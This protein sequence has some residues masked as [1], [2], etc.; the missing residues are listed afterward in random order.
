MNDETI[1]DKYWP[2][3]ISILKRKIN[4]GLVPTE[5]IEYLKNRYSDSSSIYESLYRIKNHIEEV[6]T[7]KYCGKKLNYMTYKDGGLYCGLSCSSRDSIDARKEA[8]F[9]KYGCYTTLKDPVVRS[10]IK[11]TF[12]HKSKKEKKEIY[13]K[14]KKTKIEKYGLDNWCGQKKNSKKW[15]NKSKEELEEINKKKK[16]TF[17]NHYGVDNW[18]KTKEYKEFASSISKE[19]QR[20]GYVT[21]KK[22]GTLYKRHSISEQK[23]FDIL[24]IIYPDIIR[25]YRDEERYPWKCDFYVPS[26]DLFIEFQGFYTHGLHPYDPISEEDIKEKERLIDR[27]GKDSQA[28]TIWTIKDVEKRETAKKNN[29]NYLEFFDFKEVEE[30]VKEKSSVETEA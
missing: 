5:D 20:K 11:E 8:I 16:E 15:A 18:T 2:K 3:K 29:L 4:V 13:E 6:P 7:C 26:K 12:S 23:C 21:M 30:Y 1:L 14:Q 19:V 25:E 10:K 22:N 9:K 17:L 28:V 24:H 27:Y